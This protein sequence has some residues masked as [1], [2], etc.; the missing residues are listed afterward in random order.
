MFLPARRV[1]GAVVG[2]FP[3]RN[4]ANDEGEGSRTVLLVGLWTRLY[5]SHKPRKPETFVF[6]RR[7]SHL[8]LFLVGAIP[9]FAVAV[10][11]RVVPDTSASSFPSL[12]ID[13]AVNRANL[14]EGRW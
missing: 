4:A 10:R 7:R 8:A 14:G 13:A 12:V 3:I 5:I 11:E 2:S 9:A 6:A 1:R